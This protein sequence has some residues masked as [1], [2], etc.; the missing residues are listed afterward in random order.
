[1]RPTGDGLKRQSDPL[2]SGLTQC[3]GAGFLAGGLDR[4]LR[5]GRVRVLDLGELGLD[6]VVV[7]ELRQ[8][9]GDDAVHV[10]LG[11]RLALV[12]LRRVDRCTATLRRGVGSVAGR[13]G[14]VDVEQ[15]DLASV[16]AI[17]YNR[18]RAQSSR[19]PPAGGKVW[20]YVM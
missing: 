16:H 4:L 17:S 9:T 3:F 6:L 14:R 11:E 19:T 5:L 1:M 20:G 15:R 12:G 8:A 10:G 18:L 7:R 13:L 2:G